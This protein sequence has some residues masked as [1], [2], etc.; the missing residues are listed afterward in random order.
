MA[1]KIPPSPPK[2]RDMATLVQVWEKVPV[3]TRVRY[4]QDD[5]SEVL[6]NTRSAP[7]LMGGHSAMIQL[8]GMSGSFALWRVR[9]VL[10]A[11]SFAAEVQTAGDGD[12]WTGNALRFATKPE[13]EEYAKDL[14][15]R[16]TA[17]KAFR[18]VEST[19]PVNR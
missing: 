1:S 6:T 9:E 14:F 13:A 3:G 11:T 19:D 10:K 7:F 15:S 18:V 17:V 2:K 4:V 5:G 8:E 16:W 12:A